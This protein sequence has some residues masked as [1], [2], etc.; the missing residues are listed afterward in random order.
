LKELESLDRYSHKSAGY[1]KGV[2]NLVFYLFLIS[3]III[4][5]IFGY[6][7][8]NIREIKYLFIVNILLVFVFYFKLFGKYWHP[9]FIFLGTLTLFQGGLIIFGDYD[10]YSYVWLMGANFSL[11]ETAIR[12]TFLL[13]S[14]SYWFTLIGGYFGKKSI[15]KDKNF[16]IYSNHFLNRIKFFF[17]II[18][19]LTLPFYVYKQ[20]NYF[21]FFLKYGY[22]AF[23]QTSDY[24]EQVGY[25]PRAISFITP[26]AFLC[27][28][29]L[30]RKKK[31]I[32]FISLPFFIITL[33]LLFSGFR[34][35]FF[36]FWLTFLLFYKQKFN[37]HI[38]YKSLFV[39]ISIIS[40][41]GL[42]ISLFREGIQINLIDIFNNNPIFLF[43][44]QQGVSY[45]VTAMAIEFRHEF[46]PRIFH[47][48]V[49]EPFLAIFTKLGG[50]PGNSFAT[51]LMI[52]INYDGFLHG[53]GVGSTYLAEAYLLGGIPFACFFS[54][55]L[56][57]LISRLFS[58]FEYTTIF[59]KLIIFTFMQYI[60]FLPRD[61]L[62]MPLAQTVKV[63]FYLPFLYV[64]LSLVAELFKGVNE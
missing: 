46:A 44:K 9:I 47:Y 33:S 18:Y 35:S 20:L 36:T 21:S 2:N 49:I 64:I 13:I 4:V 53:Y 45:Y 42:M 60:A 50:T 22:I 52:K 56:G 19:F 8:I 12:L 24:L 31:N 5:N 59:N 14:L 55:V 16:S 29:L 48:L 28:F 3:F 23:Y 7:F 54:F 61:L 37:N 6:S 27:F 38:S 34:G 57:F 62:F 39:L 30:E 40:I 26:L 10:D 41:F 51:D 32:L 11:T 25:I 15:V 17:L 43:F 58:Y 1:L 63:A